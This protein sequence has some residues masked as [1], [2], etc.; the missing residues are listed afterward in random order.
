MATAPVLR[1]RGDQLAQLLAELRRAARTG[2]G[3]VV[4]ITGEGGIGKTALLRAGIEQAVRS[5][6]RVGRAKAEELDQI[7]PGAPLLVALRSGSAP[8]LDQ[9]SFDTL[10]PVQ[11]QPLWLADRIAGLMEEQARHSPVV[12][13]VDDVQWADRLTRFA[14]RLLPGRLTGSPVVWLLTSRRP[15]GE[16][17]EELASQALADVRLLHL[18]LGPLGQDDLDALALDH[19]GAPPAEPVRQRLHRSGGNPFLAVRLLQ[20]AA[21]DPDGPALPESL[22]AEVRSRLRAWPDDVAELIRLLSVWGRPLDLTVAATLLAIPDDRAFELAERVSAEGVLEIRQG[23]AEFRHDLLREAVYAAVPGPARRARHQ[24]CAEYLLTAGAGY[25]A[26]A[27]HAQAGAEFGDRWAAEILA[28]A[29]AQIVATTPDTA[30]ELLGQAFA[31]LPG[32]DPQFFTV[33]EQYADILIQTQHGVAAL[34]VIDTLLARAQDLQTQARLQIVATR[35]LW[36]TGSLAELTRRLAGTLARPGVAPDLRL[37]MEATRALALTRTGEPRPAAV[38]AEAALAEAR[39]RGNVPAQVLALQALGEVARNE[40]RFPVAL[41]HF[42]ELRELGGPRHQWEEIR[43]LQLLDRFDEAQVLLTSAAEQARTGNAQLLPSVLHTQ[44]WQDYN[45]GNLDRAEAGANAMV[46]LGDELG[47]RIHQLGVWTFLSSIALTR[48]DPVR[49]RKYL[50]PIAAD[51]AGNP[52]PD[53]IRVLGLRLLQAWISAEEGDFEG[54]LEV[55]RPL[56]SAAKDSRRYWPWWPTYAQVF[57]GVGLAAGDPEFTG[58]ALELTRL[59]AERNPGVPSFE[60]VHLHAR[61]LVQRDPALLGEAVAVL[62]KSPRR[63]LLANV[64]TDHGAALLQAGER[65]PAL[66]SLD[67]AWAIEEQLRSVSGQAKIRNILRTH[68]IRRRGRSVATRSRPGSGWAA[69][70]GTEL[71]IAELVS[72]GHTNRQAAAELGISVNTVSTHLRAVFAKLGVSSRVQ[73][74]NTWRNRP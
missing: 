12:V 53:D 26:A 51:I 22:V 35:A 54:S 11:D 57:V 60:G 29:A 68:G 42:R 6:F 58:Q 37:Q 32:E 3:A 23:S 34:T 17:L 19:L 45:L 66:K 1:G 38:V 64:L 63:T 73:L 67:E 43:C 4:L 49:A 28:G 46:R 20:G 15:A 56:V 33:G 39:T 65:A 48:A 62:R 13:A 40:G 7:A 71:R 36:V 31:L 70:T 74:S 16:L 8:L 9:A 44:I 41:G 10:A 69:L 61:A 25:P 59:G 18:E 30:R 21:L 5:G 47:L 52:M 24:Q 27:A 50:E 72:Q 55:L 2:R 14:L